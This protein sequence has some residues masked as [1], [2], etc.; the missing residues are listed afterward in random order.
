[1]S[2]LSSASSR[3]GRI[4]ADV[5]VDFVFL[6]LEMKIQ[7]PLLRVI[8]D[9]LPLVELRHV[10]VKLVV[11]FDERPHVVAVPTCVVRKKRN[12]VHAFR[13]QVI[14]CADERLSLC[15]LPRGIAGGPVLQMRRVGVKR[16]L[17]FSRHG[18]V[19]IGIRQQGLGRVRAEF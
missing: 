2:P 3:L 17:F 4:A 18:A 10:V 19:E 15:V 9:D 16:Y 6:Q 11:P 13:R 5:V 14:D 7:A 8:E 12:R 1:V